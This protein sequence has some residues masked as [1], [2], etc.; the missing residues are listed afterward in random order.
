MARSFSDGVAIHCVLLVLWVTSSFHTT[1]PMGGRAWLLGGLPVG[2]SAG[3]AWATATHRL[4]SSVGRLAGCIS[5]VLAVQRLDSDAARDGSALHA[6]GE[7][8]TVTE[9]CYS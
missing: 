8:C 1:L 5:Q 9:V 3:R 7:L 4:C 6:S 2:V